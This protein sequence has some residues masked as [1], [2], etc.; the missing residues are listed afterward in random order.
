MPRYKTL[1]D[2][3]APLSCWRA[4][5]EVDAWCT[6]CRA[7]TTHTIL[8]MAA[9]EPARVMC[10]TC[11]SQHNY[12]AQAPHSKTASDAKKPSGTW[13]PTPKPSPQKAWQQASQGKDLGNPLPYSPRQTYLNGQVILHGKFG[14]GIVMGEREGGKILVVFE[15]DTRV[16]VHGRN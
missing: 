16:L 7:L 12:K 13:A 11:K 2:Y 8:A 9:G 14:T 10:T 1:G 6:R 3:A 5:G 15:D 4:G